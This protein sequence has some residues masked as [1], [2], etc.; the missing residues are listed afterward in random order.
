M[1]YGCF[2]FVPVCVPFKV[3]TKESFPGERNKKES[4]ILSDLRCQNKTSRK[5]R[6]ASPTPLQRW[7]A[8]RSKCVSPTSMQVVPTS[9]DFV[10]AQRT[11]LLVLISASISTM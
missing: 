11:P 8:A 10:H 7:L 6:R 5:L 9:R 2:Y 1:A 4:L 3:H